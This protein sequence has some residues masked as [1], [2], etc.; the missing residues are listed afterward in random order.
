M[1]TIRAEAPPSPACLIHP[2][3]SIATL[4][5]GFGARVRCLAVEATR[6]HNL[7]KPIEKIVNSTSRE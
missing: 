5:R 2:S 3:S 6:E 7:R 4:V 1:G